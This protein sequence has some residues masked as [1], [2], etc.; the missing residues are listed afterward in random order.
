MLIE[1]SGFYGLAHDAIAFSAN[2]GQFTGALNL[3]NAHRYGVEV[4]GAFRVFQSLSFAGNY[5]WVESRRSSNM[6]SFDGK[7]LPGRPR[8]QLYGRVDAA[9]TRW[10]R[11]FAVWSDASV[12]TG[13]F[14]DAANLNSMPARFL[15][16]TGVK[17]EVVPGVLASIEVKNLLNQRVETLQLSPAPSPSLAQIDRAVSDVLGYPLPGRAFYL[18]AEWRFR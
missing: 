10:Q 2:A 7:V 16:G 4:A 3:G 14:I 13:N 15:V 6:P 5:T 12:A 8:H 11:T 9:F 1:A 18:Q 17:A